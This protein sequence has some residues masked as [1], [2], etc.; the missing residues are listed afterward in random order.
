MNY[1]IFRLSFLNGVHFGEGSLN[2]S[3]IS[4]MADTLFSAM[5]MEA[6]KMGNDKLELLISNFKNGDT[7]ISDAF[8]Y[9]DDKYYIPKPNIRIRSDNNSNSV[10]KKM[11]KKTEYIDSALI[12]SF[13]EGN[14]PEE[15]L[16]GLSK[17]GKKDTRTMVSIRGNEKTEPFRVGVFS[18]DKTAGLYF[19]V[20]YTNYDNLVLISELMDSLEMSGIGGKRSSGLGRFTYLTVDLPEYML[21]RINDDRSVNMLLSLALP[22]EEELSGVMVNSNYTLIKR[23][24]FIASETYAD[25]LRKK[26][27][28]FV[29]KAGSCFEKT[30]TGDIYDV[31]N[32]GKHPVYRYARAMFIGI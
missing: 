11:Y 27:D 10:I 14:Y 12:D 32:G 23:S 20:G 25:E 28:I 8:P 22:S 31:S 16:G 21:H 3:G 15:F 19:I 17:L 18:F 7:L 30:F 1:K 24:G 4:F 5:C 6:L 13:V 29:F 2:E 9:I 26:K